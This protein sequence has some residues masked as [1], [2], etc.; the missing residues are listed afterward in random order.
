M[1][2]T[3]RPQINA[4]KDEEKEP[5]YTVGEDKNWAAAVENSKTQ[6]ST[7]R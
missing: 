2:I 5:L 7:P 4:G 6:H 1:A 3:K